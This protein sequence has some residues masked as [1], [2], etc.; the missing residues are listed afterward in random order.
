MDLLGEENAQHSGAEEEEE[1]IEEVIVEEPVHGHFS[2]AAPSG[3][4]GGSAFAMPTSG[5]LAEWNAKH[6][7]QL[8]EK[9]KAAA[10]RR[11][12]ALEQAKEETQ[13]LYDERE[14]KIKAAKSENKTAE[15]S[16]VQERDSQQSV[17]SSWQ[18]VDYLISLASARAG[19][20]ADSGS[21]NSVSSGSGD[22][23][24]AERKHAPKDTTRFRQ[25]LNQLKHA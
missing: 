9:E 22:A 15:A 7:T 18:R 20:S 8:A 17:G 25:V 11:K 10:E 19:K 14:K 16:F 2:A 12:R 24:P 21:S 3:F 6:E 1:V 13:R 4:G 23:K 5:P